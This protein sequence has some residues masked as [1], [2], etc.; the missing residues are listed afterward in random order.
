MKNFRNLQK[1]F[2]LQQSFRSIFARRN[3]LGNKSEGEHKKRDTE[4]YYKN[5]ARD[6][7]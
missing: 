3:N 7:H 6:V 1:N 2:L 4:T 5:C